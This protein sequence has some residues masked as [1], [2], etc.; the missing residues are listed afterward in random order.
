MSLV[1]KSLALDYLTDID[2]LRES[3]ALEVVKE[4]SNFANA[5]I[6]V[7]EPNLEK[8]PNN[9][10][11]NIELVSAITALGNADLIIFLVAHSQFR[12]LD[13]TDFDEN[14]IL[15]FCGLSK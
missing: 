8:I 14:K 9:L 13:L 3:P 5:E 11:A 15:D 12:L 4:L 1:P 2:D 10:S 6:L 7:V